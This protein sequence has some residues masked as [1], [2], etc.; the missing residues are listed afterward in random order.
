V[1]L[2]NVP[3]KEFLGHN[4]DREGL[5]QIRVRALS[6]RLLHLLLEITLLDALPPLLDYLD[7]VVD[8]VHP[9]RSAC[10]LAVGMLWTRLRHLAFVR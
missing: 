5:S 4:R 2:E 1:V 9:C 3:F 7:L 10:L 6:F 8:V